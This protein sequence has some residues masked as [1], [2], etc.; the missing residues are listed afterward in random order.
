MLNN[1]LCERIQTVPLGVKVRKWT[2][3]DDNNSHYHSVVS[4]SDSP[5]YLELSWRLTAADPIQRVGLFRLNLPGL[6]QGGFI[7]HEPVD[8]LGSGI[9]F[10]IVRDGGHF[11]VQV[12]QDG[13]RILMA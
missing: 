7:R 2:L 6:L 12:N 4:L 3:R 1:E 9:R 13:P 10:R 8:S 5:L 11:Y